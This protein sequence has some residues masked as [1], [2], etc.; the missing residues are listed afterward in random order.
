M[1]RPRRHLRNRGP[2]RR[3][4]PLLLNRYDNPEDQGITDKDLTGDDK[5]EA[6]QNT[7]AARL[8]FNGLRAINERLGVK[9]VYDLSATRPSC[10]APATGKARY[11]PGWSP[12]LAWSRQSS[13]AS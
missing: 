8:W 1:P 11:S 6:R 3:S 2:Q 4:A 9:T 5:T 7:E 10:P 12:T 13:P